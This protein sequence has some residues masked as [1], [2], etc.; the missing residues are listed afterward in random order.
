M[1]ANRQ[2]VVGTAVAESS[3]LGKV[4]KH[5]RRAGREVVRRVLVLYYAFNDPDVPAWAKGTIAAAMGYFLFP[6][7]AIPDFAPFVGYA[8]DL[9]AIMLALAAVASCIKPEHRAQAQA[10]TDA[11]FGADGVAGRV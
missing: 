4:L 1:S 11:W 8:D 10:K 5:A 7:D 6:L 3:Y 9:G 2:V